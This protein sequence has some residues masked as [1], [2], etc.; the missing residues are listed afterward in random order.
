M[1][2]LWL[3]LA[4]GLFSGCGS[5]EGSS[6][7]SASE[8]PQLK[9]TNS[10]SSTTTK[11]GGVTNNPKNPGQDTND[12]PLTWSPRVSQ[13]KTKDVQIK[14]LIPELKNIKA[15]RVSESLCGLIYK[16]YPYATSIDVYFTGR[17]TIISLGVVLVGEDGSVSTCQTVSFQQDST[18]PG[19]GEI[20]INNNAVYTNSRQVKLR[21][22]NDSASQMYVTNAMSCS[23][24]GNWE[25]IPY[26]EINWTLD[27]SNTTVEVYVKFKDD[28]GNE[29]DCIKDSIIHDDIPPTVPSI[30]IANGA[31][32]TSVANV[33]LSL[34][35]L[36][37]KYVD[38]GSAYVCS[39]PT[40]ESYTTTAS[41]ELPNNGSSQQV[42]AIFAD[43]AGNRTSCVSDSINTPSV[44][45]TYYW[46]EGSYYPTYTQ[47]G[48]TK[49][50]DYTS[51]KTKVV[52]KP[53]FS[54]VTSN[55]VGNCD[56]SSVGG[57]YE[58]D[59]TDN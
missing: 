15:V 59:F 9:P 20:T 53:P 55:M 38:Y 42:F 14:L 28:V 2:E 41:Y 47:C 22:K 49:V 56:F 17:N 43:E 52:T 21:I 54:V 8:S 57:N 19:K 35:A 44:T 27:R 12:A 26:G 51:L 13:S 34:F 40:W 29:T 33:S 11:S 39:S 25:S 36:G 46:Y 32:S 16:E 24:G 30:T 37:A 1:R 6:D 50:R 5:G 4:I 45:L 23:Y 7:P 18:P 31:A 58:C 10:P 48:Y 3:I